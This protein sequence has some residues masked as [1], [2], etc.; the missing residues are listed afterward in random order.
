MNWN[1]GEKIRE[2]VKSAEMVELVKA[3]ESVELAELENGEWRM[4]TP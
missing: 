2:M 4:N 1:F 3:A